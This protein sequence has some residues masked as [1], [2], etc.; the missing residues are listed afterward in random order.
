MRAGLLPEDLFRGENIL[1]AEK[2]ETY[3]WSFIKRF[4]CPEAENKRFRLVFG[5]VD[6]VAEYFLNGRQIGSSGNISIPAA[7]I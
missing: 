3:D 4:D 7:T 5:G 6:C 2:Y 1:L